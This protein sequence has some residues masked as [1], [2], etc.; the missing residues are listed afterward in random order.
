[1]QKGGGSVGRCSSAGIRSERGSER[2]RRERGKCLA[3]LIIQLNPAEVLF[4]HIVPSSVG[5]IHFVLTMSEHEQSD[6]G[7]SVSNT[8]RAYRT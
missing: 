3:G 7:F 2:Q 6:L 5:S 8:I 4:S 1:M